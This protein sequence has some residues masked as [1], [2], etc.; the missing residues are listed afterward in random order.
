MEFKHWKEAEIR[1]NDLKAQIDDLDSGICAL[2]TEAQDKE[3][4]V[5]K[6]DKL[7]EDVRQKV[8]ERDSLQAEYD[9][10]VGVRDKLKATE[11]KQFGIIANVST[12]RINERAKLQ[13]EEDMDIYETRAY[14]L[15][16]ANYIKTGNDAEVRGLVNTQ[17]AGSAG[18]LVPRN[19][20]NAI[21]DKVRTAGRI[22]ALCDIINFQG[23]TEYPVA[24]T[25]SDPEIH[26]ETGTAV[27]KEKDISI[28]SVSMEPQFIAEILRTTRKFEADSISAFWDWIMAE[29]PDA[30][31]RVI[32]KKIFSGGQAG[33]DG[34]HGILTNTN[35]DFVATLSTHIL[36]F[37]TAN[38]AV[39]LLDDGVEDN[40]TMVMNRKTFFNDVM[41][42]AGTD[43]HPIWKQ[44]SDVSSGKPKF[45]MGGYPVEFTKELPEYAAAT[46]GQP[47]IVAGD[48]KAM[49]LNFPEGFAPNI[50][51]DEITEMDKNIIRYLSEIYVAGNITRLGHF[52]KVTK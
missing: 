16:W 32:D 13:K 23:I 48:F 22:L 15:A 27:K 6:R 4:S 47:Y 51:R 38:Q 44:V 19:L 8:E 24:G 29:L 11:E 26:D 14:E 50:I 37:N 17:T 9:E 42:L 40:V 25:R 49:K 7:I 34:I 31:R 33:K 21:G 43:G 5:E 52:V 18:L 41:G 12:K 10:T 28:L 35:S 30:L 36:D 46:S 45:V 39:A 1:V 20:V 2:E 3:I